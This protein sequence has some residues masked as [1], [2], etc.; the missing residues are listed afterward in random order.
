MNRVLRAMM[1]ALLAG[2]AAPAAQAVDGCV[3]LLCLAGNWSAIA[4]CV[5]PVEELFADLALG[6]PF[7]SCALALAP[8]L[9]ASAP[10]PAQA[11]AAPAPNAAAGPTFSTLEGLTQQNCPVQYAVQIGNAFSC[12]GYTGL[13]SVTVD[14]SPWSQTLWS[15]GG[16]S[17]TCYSSAAE[18]ALGISS[19]ACDQALA[20]YNA[21]VA[22]RSQGW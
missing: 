9:P 3:V 8:S 2:A 1:M 19:T 12:S 16:A 20:T 10:V 14:G 11:P 7:P 21:Q 22:A 4:Q 6:Q 5:P 17:V 13:I 15:P 18:S